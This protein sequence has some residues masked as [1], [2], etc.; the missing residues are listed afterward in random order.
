MKN[1]IKR[2]QSQACLNFAERK[3]FRLQAKHKILMTLALLLTAVT[4]A[5]A[6]EPKVYDSGEV[7]LSSLQVGDIL[8]PGVTLKDNNNSAGANI[9]SNRYSKDGVISQ[10]SNSIS[11]IPFSIGENGL[12]IAE[13]AGDGPYN[14]MPITEDG[15]AGNAWVVT[16]VFA[17]P[18]YKTILI[19]GTTYPAAS[20]VNINW[21]PATKTGT[22]TM[23]AFD[24]LLTPIYAPEFTATFKAGNA[25][26]IQGGKATVTVTE[27]DGTTAYTGATLDENGNYKPLYEGQT[28]TLTA[29]TGYKF[30]SVSVEKKAAVTYPLLSAATAEDIGKVVCADGHLHDAKTAVP[31]GCTAVGILG[32]VTETGHGLILALQNATAQTWETINGWTSVT[33]YAGTTLK[34]L[35]DDAARGTNLT[36]YTTL[37]ETTVSNWAVGQY[38]D[39]KAIFENLGSTKSDQSGYTYDSNV[40]A[41]ITTGVGGDAISG[42]YWSATDG[43]LGNAWRFV[44]D[45]WNYA[46]KDESFSVRPVLAF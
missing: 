17:E 37:G 3:N 39:Y 2:A 7:E 8:L 13:L 20:D 31:D 32:K 21:D 29:A 15:K 26:T 34:L 30:K 14:C 11:S 45:Y 44:S 4:G 41:Y 33:T 5:W 40:N 46:S 6:D 12:L 43:V 28:I 36:S 27:S 19:C 24:V 35:P 42:N 25:N 9:I 18:N 38:E 16:D 23:P 22:F 1:S 10:Y